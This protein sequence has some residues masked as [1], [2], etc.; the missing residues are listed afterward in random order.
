MQFPLYDAMLIGTE[1]PPFDDDAYIYEIKMDGVRCLA[2]LYKDHVELINK[3]H[4]KLNSKFPELK[5]L[6]KQAKKPCVIDGELHVFQDGKSDFFA[7]QRRTLTSD[8]FRIRQHSKKFPAVFTAF[9]ILNLDGEDLCQKPLM[10]R[11]KL[12]EKNIKESPICNISRYIEQEGKALFALTKQQQLE[13]IVAKRK[14]SLYQ[15]GKRTK[16]WIKCK[17]LLEADFAVVGYIPKEY[18]MLSLVLAAYDNQKLQYCGH[19]TM[20]VSKDYLFAHIKDTIPCPFSVLPD[21]NEDATWI[22]PFLCGTV[23]FME[24]TQNGGM[25]QPVFKGFREDKQPIE[26]LMHQLQEH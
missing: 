6:Y 3:R 22:S 5:S 11:K 8:P 20:G 7:I 23:K 24:Y 21:G 9:D 10:E 13:G 16:E 26:C 14:E 2:Y 25:R 17:H 15:P 4:L 12:L 1:Q 18:A 19:V